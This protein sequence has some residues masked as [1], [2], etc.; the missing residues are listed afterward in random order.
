MVDTGPQDQHL[1]PAVVRSALERV[2]ASP[3]FNA[4]PRN[5]AFLAYIVDEALAGRGELIKAYSIAISVFNRDPDFDP[6]L[7]SIVRIEAGRLRRALDLYYLTAGRDDPIRI[8]VPRGGYV[9][10]L[11]R[12]APEVA[13]APE[14]RPQGTRGMRIAVAAFSQESDAARY[15]DFARGLTRAIVVALTRFTEI[16]VYGP[17]TSARFGSDVDIQRL[18]DELDVQYV[19]NGGA[20]VLGDHFTVDVLLIET[21]SGRTVWA[22]TFD[23]P[24]NPTEVVRLRNDVANRL[25]STLAQPYS[26]L[27]DKRSS[28]V[29]G[30]LPASFKSYD[31]VMRFYQY[32]RTFDRK[33]LEPLRQAL[34]E[35]L[36]R[37]PDYAEAHA[38]LARVY[39]DTV[40][41]GSTA[42]PLVA[43]PL[44]RAVAL[45]RRAVDLAPRSSAARFALGLALWFVEGPARGIAELEEGL[46]LNPNDA[47]IMAELGQRYAMR[48]DWE[49]AL[50]MLA[51]ADERNPGQPSLL[52]FGQ[53][54]HAYVEGRYEDAL[55]LARKMGPLQVLHA[56]GAVAIAAAKAGRKA[57]A[58]AALAEVLRMEPEYLLHAREDLMKRN[59]HPDLVDLLLDGLREAAAD[60]PGT[61]QGRPATSA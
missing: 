53:F 32:A 36:V 2:L 29:E 46:K 7:D 15:P 51:A 44:E 25:V 61:F 58:R 8:S 3:E 35:V 14:P 33:L 34:E 56:P 45:A 10:A 27:F 50:P 47:N 38:C 24:L 48:M 42:G 19:L 59:L 13:L 41:F 52:R 60:L 21:G 18:R 43:A 9:P 17:E 16:F 40:R 5:R 49:R 55:A 23:R 12:P 4:S 22:D 26:A 28:D 37:D 39:V 11:E 30:S 1:D 31:A 20:C 6:Q 57:E 54:L